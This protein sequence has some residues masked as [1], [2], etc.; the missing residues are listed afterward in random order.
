MPSTLFAGRRRY[1]E[2]SCDRWFVLSAKHRLVDPDDLLDPYDVTLIGA[3]TA[4][5]RE[6]TNVVLE[7]LDERLG[8][9]GKHTF[10]IHAGR[11]YWGY[12]L[13]EGL[14]RS[15]AKVTIPTKGLGIGKQLSFYAGTRDS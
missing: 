11:D 8:Y 3:S 1:V 13:L 9:L 5:K 10:E 12:G 4:V 14:E 6:W 2:K 7:E 15:G